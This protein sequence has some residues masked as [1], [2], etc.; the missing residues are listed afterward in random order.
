MKGEIEVEAPLIATREIK[1]SSGTPEIR[2]IV[3]TTLRIF[4]DV[5]PIE[6][7]LSRR[8]AMGFRMLIGREALRRR[9]VV[10]PSRS[11]LGNV[12]QERRSRIR[13]RRTERGLTNRPEEKK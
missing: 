13:N 5:I 7:A 2:P 10:D 1:P 6:L 4:G 12:S 11:Y 9:I 3:A 8:D